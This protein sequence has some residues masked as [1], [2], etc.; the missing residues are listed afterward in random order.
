M[1]VLIKRYANRKL[2][3][4]ETSRYITLKGIADLLEANQEVRVIDNETGE[5]ITSVTLSQILVDTERDGRAVPNNLISEIF[6][7]GGDA[8]YE[9]GEYHLF[10]TAKAD[11]ASPYDNYMCNS[12]IVRLTGPTRS[13]PFTFAAVVLDTWHHEAHAVRTPAPWLH[14]AHFS[15]HAEAARIYAR[16]F[17][18]IHTPPKLGKDD[19]D[20]SR[21]RLRVETQSELQLESHTLTRS[22][23]AALPALSARA[24]SPTSS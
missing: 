10:V 21:L 13:G 23:P 3:N 2:Y 17:M 19:E 18:P 16:A 24:V 6:Q 20:A 7:K 5:D 4:T 14:R 11:P 15:Q 22:P 12:R 8:I 1:A 9:G